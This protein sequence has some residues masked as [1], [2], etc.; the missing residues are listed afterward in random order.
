MSQ[1][2]TKSIFETLANTVIGFIISLVSQ[3]IIFHMFDIHL[4]LDTNI[5][6]SL[7]FTAIS[8]IRGYLVRR[9]FNSMVKK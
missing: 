5:W 8:L 1:T 9:W 6:I 2:R 3:L 4:P 7:W